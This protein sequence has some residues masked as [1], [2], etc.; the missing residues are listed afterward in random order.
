M[1]K[2]INTITTRPLRTSDN[3]AAVPA[4]MLAAAQSIPT[5]YHTQNFIHRATALQFE[6]KQITKQNRLFESLPW[7]NY[8]TKKGNVILSAEERRTLLKLL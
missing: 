7:A 6:R 2:C 5:G 1:E 4:A 8:V 3:A